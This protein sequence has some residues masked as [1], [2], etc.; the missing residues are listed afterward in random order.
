MSVE[1]ISIEDPDDPRLEPYR[2]V[3]ERDLVGRKGRFIAEGRLVV[4]ALLTGT[5]FRATSVLVSPPALEAIREDLALAE[6]SPTVYVASVDTMSAVAG[7]HIHR[8][9]LAV[10]ERLDEP[11]VRELVA[12]EGRA[13][14]LLALEDLSNHDNV[15][16]VFRSAAAFGADGVLLSPRCCDPL[17]RK[18]IRV[19]MACALRVPFARSASW[20]DDLD[21]LAR[22]GY[23]RVA[24]VLDPDAADIDEHVLT[25]AERVALVLGAEGPG[26]TRATI[27]RCDA[28][29]RIPIASEVDSLNAAVAGAIALHRYR[30]ALARRAR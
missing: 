1:P 16:G 7:F 2:D 18:A 8:G 23:E 10:G 3:R 4:S 26:L 12:P 24:L 20:S 22:A 27:E 17:Y 30:A 11:G 6:P 9:C 5:R 28:R 14:L 21:A 15:G 29:V 13:S 25:C 19:S